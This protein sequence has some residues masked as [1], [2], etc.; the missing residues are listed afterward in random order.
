MELYFTDNQLRID[1]NRVLF[2]QDHRV[3]FYFES[4]YSLL[5]CLPSITL[6]SPP[7]RR[8]HKQLHSTGTLLSLAIWCA[9]HRPFF[10]LTGSY[11]IKYLLVVVSWQ[12]ITPRQ[13]WPCEAWDVLLLFWQ[14]TV[15]NVLGAKMASSENRPLKASLVW[16]RDS[17]AAHSRTWSGN[18]RFVRS[19]MGKLFPR[20]SSKKN[21][22]WWMTFR[23]WLCSLKIP[24]ITHSPPPAL[25]TRHSIVKWHY[26]QI[27]QF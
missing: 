3:E 4:I 13:C 27:S 9:T 20:R 1:I 22:V 21:D 2:Q 17:L 7:R 25:I 18:K 26:S 11:T 12:S 23:L 14:V 10:L 15:Q 8:G 19:L 16:N 24:V 6:G 5:R